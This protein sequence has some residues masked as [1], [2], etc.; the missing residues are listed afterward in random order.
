MLSVQ[1]AEAK[2]LQMVQSLAEEGA[3][4]HETVSLSAAQGRILAED[5]VSGQDFPYW[6]H[7]AMDGYAVRAEDLQGCTTAQPISLQVVMEIPAGRAPT[8]ALQTGQAAR[9]FTG[10]MMPEG[11][12][13]VIMQEQAERIGDRVTF[14]TCPEAQAWVR[15]KGDY[16]RAGQPLLKR[17]TCLQGVDLAILASAQ[18]AV[19]SVYRP[20]RVSVFSTGNEL[21]PPGQPLQP[22]Q[23]TDSNQLTL[24]ALVQQ[25]GAIAQPLGIVPDDRSSLKRAIASAIAEADVVISSGGVSVGDYDYVEE[26]L[27]ELGGTLHIQSVAVKPGKPLTVAT[28]DHPK[29][30]RPV[31]YFGL[32]GNPVSAPVGFWRFVQPALR[33]LSGLSQGWEAVFVRAKTLQDLRADGKRET[34]LWGQ[35]FLNAEGIHE[36]ELAGGIHSSGNLINL[37]QTNGLAVLQCDRPSVEVG[38]WVLVMQVGAV[39]LR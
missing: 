24:T 6:D 33:K 9:I 38:D 19:V 29:R 18:C 34:Y 36:F 21:V 5:I 7:S 3:Q 1:E 32:P 13:A 22:G 27:T 26:V 2:I 8:Q 11:T 30:D 17:G 39:R 25:T 10:S 37:A 28:F 14:S 23:I 4:A 12:N 31:L 35:L 20:V 16:Y 15:Q